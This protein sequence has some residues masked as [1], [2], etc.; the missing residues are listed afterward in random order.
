MN[1]N[2]NYIEVGMS[3][4]DDIR[5]YGKAQGQGFDVYKTI[6]SYTNASIVDA[7]DYSTSYVARIDIDENLGENASLEDKKNALEDINVNVN[8]DKAHGEVVLEEGKFILYIYY[9]VTESKEIKEEKLSYTLE[10]IELGDYTKTISFKQALELNNDFTYYPM[11]YV[12]LNLKDSN[13]K[14]S[15]LKLNASD[16]FKV[17]RSF[18]SN[19]YNKQQIVLKADIASLIPSYVNYDGI[20]TALTLT[21]NVASKESSTNNQGS[22]L[23]CEEYMNSKNWTWSETKKACVYRVSNTSSK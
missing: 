18:D 12:L 22:N 16:L 17:I 21:I 9:P 23:S 5:I 13:N 20:D 15:G 11:P 1:V 19:N 8:L 3:L 7:A 4:P 14:T 2:T 10:S 6:D